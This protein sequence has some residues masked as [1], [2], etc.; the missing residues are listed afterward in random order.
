MV[1]GPAAVAFLAGAFLAFLA[2]G[3]PSAACVVPAASPPAREEREQA[4]E[5]VRIGS[6][7]E[8]GLRLDFGRR[9]DNGAG[10]APAE[11]SPG[12]ASLRVKVLWSCGWMGGDG[13]CGV[14]VWRGRLQGSSRRLQLLKLALQ[15]CHAVRLRKWHRTGGHPG[16]P[17]AR[18]RV[19]RALTYRCVG[20]SCRM[21]NDSFLWSRCC[22]WSTCRMYC[23]VGM[24]QD[25]STAS[26][27]AV[28]LMA[29]AGVSQGGRR[30]T[31]V[32]RYALS[33]IAFRAPLSRSPFR[34][35]PSRSQFYMHM[36]TLPLQKGI[37]G[38]KTSREETSR[39]YLS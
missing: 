6:M 24:S 14:C 37:K 17:H 10:A 5:R 20:S 31:A 23:R 33:P 22:S 39:N 35:T 21:T 18:F 30:R 32:S 13:V 16:V 11:L 36:F 8:I 4:G 19:T 25:S 12:P 26:S 15:Q 7:R 27:T 34:I 1:T 2:G 29:R 3:A 28:Q 38:T 9:V